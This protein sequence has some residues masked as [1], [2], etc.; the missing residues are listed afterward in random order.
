M[1]IAKILLPLSIGIDTFHILYIIHIYKVQVQIF[2]SLEYLQG[3]S[4]ISWFQ[5]K[6]APMEICYV[7]IGL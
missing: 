2:C 7:F 6:N 5:Y 3:K 1:C 4:I